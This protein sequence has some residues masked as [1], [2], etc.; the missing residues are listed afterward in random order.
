M[1]ENYPDRIE[2]VAGN[3]KI[4]EGIYL[5]P[6]TTCGLSE[7]GKQEM[8]YRRTKKGW[9]PDDFSHE[10]SL[11]LD[12]EKGLLIINSCSHG[13]VANIINE[14]REAFPDKKIYGYIGGFHLFNKSNEAIGEVAEM[15]SQT[16]VD[17]ICT[18]HCTGGRAYGILKEKLGD[19][20]IAFSAEYDSL[21][22]VRQISDCL[23][24][25]D[26]DNAP[27]DEAISKLKALG[28]RCGISSMKHD[29][30]TAEYVKQVRDAGFEV[31]SSIFKT[32]REVESYAN[33]VTYVLSDFA[34]FPA[35][36]MKAKMS[37]HESDKTLR[38]GE[39]ITFTGKQ[40][41]YSSLEIQIDIKGSVEVIVGGKRHYTFTHADGM[42]R[43]GSWRF[44]DTA[45]TIEIVAK[46]N[47]TIK[48]VTINQY[49]Y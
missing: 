32:P 2:K 34:L 16:S 48:A 22:P 20:F 7:I 1:L 49:K 44:Y 40:F 28:G 23:I 18:G 38:T 33:G 12:T 15:I 13:G 19:N 4:S 27:A 29:L 46:E 17:Y 41:K 8:M 43:I 26:P 5:I 21:R 25:W 9:M 42:Q 10:Q 24:L 3:Y 45:P 31:Q 39:K 37:L 36:S 35:K 14:V 47:S 11:V 6:H 30:L